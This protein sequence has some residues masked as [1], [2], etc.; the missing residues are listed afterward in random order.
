MVKAVVFDFD[1][2]LADSFEVF[3]EVLAETLRRP[4]FSHEEIAELRGLPTREIMRKLNVKKWQLPRLAT[5]GRRALG[6][7]MDNVEPF[8]GM[9]SL[10]SDLHDSGCKIYILSTNDTSN[11]QNFIKK[12]GFEKY[13]TRVYGDIG[14]FGK[15]KWLKKLLKREGLTAAECIYVG[16]ETRDLEATRKAGLRCVA[17]AWGYGNPET[18]A[19]YNPH[20]LAKNPRGLQQILRN[21]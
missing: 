5:K 9:K 13:I 21:S 16:D 14:L 4:P 2:T 1:G 19:T 17:V 7:R 8:K 3:I 15:V 20:A 10:L 12:Y 18:L 6:N 11:I